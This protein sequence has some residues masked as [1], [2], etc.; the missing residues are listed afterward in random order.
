MLDTCALVDDDLA[1]SAGCAIRVTAT[2]AIR[3]LH[4]VA[5]RG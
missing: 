1:S 2:V 5:P 3:P 4:P